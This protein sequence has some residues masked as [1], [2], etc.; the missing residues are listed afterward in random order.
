[1]EILIHTDKTKVYT[2]TFHKS[3][4]NRPIGH[5]I[6]KVNINEVTIHSKEQV[7][8]LIKFLESVKPGL[9]LEKGVN[10]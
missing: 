4:F 6:E 7:D 5:L 2:N 9:M 10:F 1:M 8:Y 3:M